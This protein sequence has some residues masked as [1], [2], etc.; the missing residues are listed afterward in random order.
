[1]TLIAIALRQDSAKLLGPVIP[2]LVTLLDTHD[3]THSGTALG[4]L[5]LLNPKPPASLVPYLLP[6]LADSKASPEKLI[7]LS[8]VLIGAAPDDPTVVG[9]ILNLLREHPGLRAELVRMMG[10]AHVVNEGTIA[11]FGAGLADPDDNIRSAAV[12]AVGRQRPD[13]I[14]RF[15]K[16]LAQIATDPKEQ[17]LTRDFASLALKQAGSR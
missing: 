4:I 14:L 7:C 11:L 16:Q 5:G 17:P 8:G 13:V 2:E 1:M 15:E 10:A 6:R 9:A 12:Q 3:R